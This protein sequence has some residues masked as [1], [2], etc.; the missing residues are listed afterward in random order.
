[1]TLKEETPATKKQ[2]QTSNNL[3]VKLAKCEVRIQKLVSAELFYFLEFKIR[4]YE[5]YTTKKY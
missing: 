3:K 2:Q 1:M 4:V 5:T